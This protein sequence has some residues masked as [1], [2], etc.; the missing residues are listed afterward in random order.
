MRISQGFSLIELV[1]AAFFLSCA[2]LGLIW[3]NSASNRSSMDAYLKMQAVQLALEPIEVFR[4]FGYEW[5][6]SDA[7]PQLE[8]FP[9][10]RL[11]GI[12]DPP[13]GGIQHP[14]ECA[15]F[16]REIT[17]TPMIVNGLRAVKVR[18]RVVPHAQSRARTFLLRNDVVMEGLIVE[19]PR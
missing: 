17:L 2:L 8:Q 1:I 6:T 15:Q 12:V 7:R 4:A 16:Q 5:L 3:L 13:F 10:G 18:V 11:A 9:I 14:S 19:R